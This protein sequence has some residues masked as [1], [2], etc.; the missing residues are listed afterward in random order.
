MYK[1][2]FIIGKFVWEKTF[3]KI[4]WDFRYPWMWEEPLCSK[5][6]KFHVKTGVEEITHHQQLLLGC[7]TSESS[8]PKSRLS[9]TYYEI[10]V[11]TSV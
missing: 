3:R 6:C 8:C 5:S 10:Y 2:N 7:S 4:I 9:L 1:L 11:T